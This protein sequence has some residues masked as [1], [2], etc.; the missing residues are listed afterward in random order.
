[1]R[2]KL[3]RPPFDF[4]FS[5]RKWSRNPTRHVS[6]RSVEPSASN[7]ATFAE[8]DAL[9]QARIKKIIQADED[10]G[11]VA[12]GTPIVVCESFRSSSQLE[13]AELTPFPLE[14]KALELF[15]GTLVKAC[16][17]DAQERNVKKLTAHGLSVAISFIFENKGC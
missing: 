13:I 15:L 3:N 10:V 1:M 12:Q 17:A 6:P 9:L 16:V 5:P 11:K 7:G 2:S 14:A 8:R 4:W